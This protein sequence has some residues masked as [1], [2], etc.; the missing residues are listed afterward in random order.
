VSLLD[1]IESAPH[2]AWPS[3][4]SH[5]VAYVGH[6]PRLP[7]PFVVDAMTDFGNVDRSQ[8]NICRAFATQPEAEAH[9]RLWWGVALPLWRESLRTGLGPETPGTRRARARKAHVDGIPAVTRARA[10]VGAMARLEALRVEQAAEAA[11]YAANPWE[12]FM[13]GQ[14]SLL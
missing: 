4:T 9:A 3:L 14:L 13:V 11:F 6:Y 10:G 8:W 5:C 7:R 1:L 12:R 2:P